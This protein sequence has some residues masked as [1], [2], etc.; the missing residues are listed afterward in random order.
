[1]S[2]ARPL[3]LRNIT[4][5]SDIF[6]KETSSGPTGIYYNLGNVAIGK[7]IALYPLDVSGNVNATTFN[8][9]I[10]GTVGEPL[11][12]NIAI[13]SNFVVLDENSIDNIAIG[14]SSLNNNFQSQ[15][16][17]NIGI[18]SSSLS[19]FNDANG[20]VGI[21]SFSFRLTISGNSN[22]GIGNNSGFLLTSGSNNT[23]LG[24]SSDVEQNI[25]YNNSTALGA[26]AIITASNQ[27]V[28]G[29]AAEIVMIPGSYV[30]FGGVYNPLSD[31]ALDV[32][33][34]GNFSGAVTSSNILNASDYRIKSNITQLD[35]TFVIDK[36]N[37]V[38]YFN[39]NLGKQDIG[40]IAHELQENYPE[41]VIG[42]KDGEYNQ[43]VNYIG[44]IPILIKEIQNLKS[45]VK[46]L[47]E[48]E[49]K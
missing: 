1:M 38:T 41:L 40:L 25:I 29:T 13:G 11:Q 46:I 30:G 3:Y 44:L 35:N 45:R 10:F 34:N 2:Y 9:L 23:F 43:S 26:G 12:N 28:L 15:G 6:W 49:S 32:S 21:G 5:G 19:N 42:E 31:Y 47:E 22:V 33:G 18:G 37:P 36:L 27:I 14:N 8:N 24:A 7:D 4:G 39:N 17:N 16:S 48:R 20:N